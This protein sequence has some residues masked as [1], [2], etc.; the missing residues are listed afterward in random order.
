MQDH[1]Y[2]SRT[3]VGFAKDRFSG[4]QEILPPLASDLLPLASWH[5]TAT[6]SGKRV[7]NSSGQ[8]L[9]ALGEW[10]VNGIADRLSYARYRDQEHCF[11]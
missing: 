7:P 10:L 3:T 4:F 11:L 9:G 2:F 1:L 5:P 6:A 8:F